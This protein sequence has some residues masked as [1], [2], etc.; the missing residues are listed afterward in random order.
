MSLVGK[1]A[2]HIP[3]VAA[4]EKGYVLYFTNSIN[5]AERIFRQIR[6]AISEAYLK[7]RE[8]RVTKKLAK[9][10]PLLKETQ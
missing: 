8:R 1:I 9:I 3:L 4:S 2:L 10:R 6:D 7:I 5:L